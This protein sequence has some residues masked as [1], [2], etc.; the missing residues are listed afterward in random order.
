[1]FFKYAFLTTKEVITSKREPTPIA[2][3]S[4]EHLTE[5][6]GIASASLR[7]LE[8]RGKR[9]IRKRIFN[10]NKQIENR[11]EPLPQ[12]TDVTDVSDSENVN[13]PPPVNEDNEFEIVPVVFEPSATE[14]T[15]DDAIKKKDD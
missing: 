8:T 13:S 3:T 14:T 11:I 15:S 1:M 5:L 7:L 10:K 9:K 12:I 2:G 4:S 6:A